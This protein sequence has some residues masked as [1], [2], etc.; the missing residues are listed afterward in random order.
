MIAVPEGWLTN[1]LTTPYSFHILHY[2]SNAKYRI[3]TE[4]YTFLA[5]LLLWT[6]EVAEVDRGHS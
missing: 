6:P 4:I 2:D 1:G 3:N 5:L